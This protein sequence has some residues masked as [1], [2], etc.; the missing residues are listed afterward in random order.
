MGRQESRDVTSTR[1]ESVRG[2]KC[3]LCSGDAVLKTT[4]G[5]LSLWVCRG[6]GLGFLSPQPDDVTLGRAY[7]DAYGEAGAK[8]IGPIETLMAAS[9]AR[10]A[11]RLAQHLRPGAKVLDV[12]CGRGLIASA[13]AAAGVDVTGVERAAA[14]A[15][16]L[17][18]RVRLVVT[19]DLEHLA[20]NVALVDERFDVVMFRHVLE[21]LRDPVSAL[22][23][24]LTLLRPGG[25]VRVEVPNFQSRQADAMG[26]AWFHLD[27][28][29]HLFHFGHASLANALTSA[30]FVDV[31]VRAGLSAAQ[32][33][34]GWIQ[35]A[36]HRVGRPEQGL[37]RALHRGAARPPDVAVDVAL[38]AL[39]GPAALTLSLVEAASGGG[40][41]L[42]ATATAA[43]HHVHEVSSDR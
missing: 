24:A 4:L 41:V 27:P 36:L 19:D 18:A 33:P 23:Q 6:C 22:R 16:G 30:G 10:E 5:A 40:G 17:D 11:S 31:D 12:G 34:M 26:K 2:V 32:D 29:R 20:E 8:F 28:P 21:H 7:D 9:A 3:P 15:V 38:A 1:D 25:V 13:L 42:R 43:P 39:L 14:A 35:S 37:Y